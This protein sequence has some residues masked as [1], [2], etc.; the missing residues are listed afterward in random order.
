MLEWYATKGE[1]IET[2]KLPPN[3]IYWL[4]IAD[5]EATIVTMGMSTSSGPESNTFW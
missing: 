4:E 3:G 5:S 1:L 2:W